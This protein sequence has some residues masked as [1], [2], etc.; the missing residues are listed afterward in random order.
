MRKFIALCAVALLSGCAALGPINQTFTSTKNPIVQ[1]TAVAAVTVVVSKDKNP[2]AAAKNIRA[3]AQKIY[4][5]AAS[6]TATVSNLEKSLNAEIARVSPNQAEAT[7]FIALAA[8]M[9]VLLNAYISTNPGGPV[10]STTL[11]SIQ[12]V[13]L[14]VISAATLFIPA[15]S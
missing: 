7:G 9:E 10:V 5:D 14:A 8:T 1:S 3:I 11:V 2:V 15:G 12:G 13:A 4:A 6:P